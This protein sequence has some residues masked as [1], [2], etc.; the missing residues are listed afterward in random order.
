MEVVYR[1][2]HP[3]NHKGP[4]QCDVYHYRLGLM[5]AYNDMQW[6]HHDAVLHPSIMFDGVAEQ[7]PERLKMDDLVCA[8]ESE[9]Q[10]LDW[11]AADLWHLVSVGYRVRQFEAEEVYR[12][13]SGR[14]VAAVLGLT[15]LA[16]V[17]EEVVAAAENKLG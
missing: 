7:L 6:R 1:I 17:T 16:D 4:Y 10:L 15:P 5:D 3:D 13:K 12:G 8:F 14:Q 11:F 9:G 2:E